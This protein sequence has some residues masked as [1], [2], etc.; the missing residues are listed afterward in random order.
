MSNV[1]FAMEG[2]GHPLN[3]YELSKHNTC[4]RNS[5]MRLNVA[6]ACI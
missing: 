1:S 2:K 3:T 4:I 6:N 5:D